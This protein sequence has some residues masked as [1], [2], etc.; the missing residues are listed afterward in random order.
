MQVASEVTFPGES[1]AA[2]YR[3]D[4]RWPAT[5]FSTEDHLIGA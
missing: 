4:A 2:R 5:L 1:L 3:E